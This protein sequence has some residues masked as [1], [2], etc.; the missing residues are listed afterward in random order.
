MKLFT[1]DF[2]AVFPVGCCLVIKAKD[3]KEAEK[4]AGQTIEHTKKFTVKEI[5]MNKSGVVVYLSGDY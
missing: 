5:G 2:K 3:K 4:L 1:V